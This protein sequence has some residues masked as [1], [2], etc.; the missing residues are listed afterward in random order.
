M[1]IEIV[2]S[3][4]DPKENERAKDLAVYFNEFIELI[5]LDFITSL[6][7]NTMPSYSYT[8]KVITNDKH[9]KM[10]N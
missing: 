5:F 8:M 10:Y 6:F 2:F 3:V 4:V 7:L 1:K 9:Y